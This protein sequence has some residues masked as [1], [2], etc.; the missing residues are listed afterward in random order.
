ML[1]AGEM[2]A[3][4]DAEVFLNAVAQAKAMAIKP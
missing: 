3:P 1:E 4:P 2:Q